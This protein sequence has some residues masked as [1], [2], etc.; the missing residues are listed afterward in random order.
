MQSYRA[1]V[2][3]CEQVSNINRLQVFRLVKRRV[4]FNWDIL[5]EKLAEAI[6]LIEMHV[7]VLLCRTEIKESVRVGGKS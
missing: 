3:I 2:T 1:I 7:D 6:S 5:P 4:P